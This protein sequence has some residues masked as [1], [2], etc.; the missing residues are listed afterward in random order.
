MLLKS[1]REGKG[2]ICRYPQNGYIVMGNIL[3][4]VYPSRDVLDCQLVAVTCAV[5]LEIR[6]PMDSLSIDNRN[7]NCYKFRNKIAIHNSRWRSPCDADCST[8]L[9][10]TCLV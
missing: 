6:Q 10:V 2:A 9:I 4:R 7:I 5:P 8:L 3:R 1:A